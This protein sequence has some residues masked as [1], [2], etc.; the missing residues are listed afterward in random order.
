MEKT[1]L[2]LIRTASWLETANLF[3]APVFGRS[4]WGRGFRLFLR[5]ILANG[6]HCNQS[7]DGSNLVQRE[8]VSRSEPCNATR[9][10]IFSNMVADALEESNGVLDGLIKLLDD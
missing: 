2:G 1:K 10:C 9:D 5:V 6:C 4:S 8:G 3:A 7:C